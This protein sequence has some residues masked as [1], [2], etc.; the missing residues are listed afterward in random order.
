MNFKTYTLLFLAFAAVFHYGF[1]RDHKTKPATT[2][3]I[4]IGTSA[5]Y[6]PYAF[7]DLQTNTVVGFD[8]DIAREVARR[9]GKE[10]TIK[11]VPFQS[12]IFGLLAE[13]IDIIAAG[14][15]PTPRRA[16]AVSF[17]NNYLEGDPLVVLYNKNKNV[18]SLE[19]LK[20]LTIVVNT[21]YTADLFLSKIPKL[22]LTR[23]D[24]PPEAIM[25]L[26]TNSVDAF[27]CAQ[28]SLNNMGKTKNL[29]EFDRFI[30]PETGD[31]YALAT[32]KRRTEFVQKINKALSS[33]KKDGTLKALQTKWDLI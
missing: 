23:L 12:L 25:S 33:M 9:M 18:N 29:D 22:K 16:K 17:S 14:I 11:D 1:F 21:G 20:E 8:V 26:S 28:S 24:T 13:D 31:S 3:S 2:N 15:S 7:I 5:D 32:S 27:V 4:V 19:E 6:P 10:C 30:I